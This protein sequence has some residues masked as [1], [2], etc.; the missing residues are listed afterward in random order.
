MSSTAFNLKEAMGIERAVHHHQR[1]SCVYLLH[2]NETSKTGF[3][4][5]EYFGNNLLS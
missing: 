3:T 2:N 5:S 1:S 4:L